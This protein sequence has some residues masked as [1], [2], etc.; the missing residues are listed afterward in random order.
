MSLLTFLLS[1]FC[2]SVQHTR[3]ST[4]TYTFQKNVR[5]AAGQQQAQM[6]LG[7]AQSTVSQLVTSVAF[8]PQLCYL[9]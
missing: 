1:L 8:L 3:T 4:H 9:L 5:H 7:T 2:V 6:N